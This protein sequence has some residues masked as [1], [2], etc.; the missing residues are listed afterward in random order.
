M[1]SRTISRLSA[2]PSSLQGP[3]NKQVKCK[4]SILEEQAE[5][6][7]C[8]DI[9]F[10]FFFSTGMTFLHAVDVVRAV[11]LSSVLYSLRKKPVYSPSA[12]A[13]LTRS[14]LEP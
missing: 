9:G 2:V 6:F 11:S 13:I 8:V 10:M 7:S 14:V 4:H 3:S 12:E 1:L 5:E